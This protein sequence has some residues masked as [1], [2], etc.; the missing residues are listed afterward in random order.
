MEQILFGKEE[1]GRPWMRYLQMFSTV[2]S[3]S[4]N[5]HLH[6]LHPIWIL[7]SPI[8]SNIYSY[9]FS[10]SIS[11]RI[12]LS[13]SHPL[14]FVSSFPLL[15]NLP[16]LDCDNMVYMCNKLSFYHPHRIEFTKDGTNLSMVPGYFY[17]GQG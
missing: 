2:I 13:L 3:V 8:A 10:S 1:N 11:P 7:S 12:S 14:Y 5:N 9:I 4:V 16:V 15:K 17:W 6:I